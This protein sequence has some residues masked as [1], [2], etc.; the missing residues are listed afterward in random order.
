MKEVFIKYNPYKLETEIKIDGQAV[1]K[2]SALN[3]GEQRL[4]EWVEDLPDILVDEC[5]VKDFKLKFY[6]TVLDYED[7][8]SVASAAKKRGITIA[9]EHIPAKEVSDNVENILVAEA[10]SKELAIERFIPKM[11]KIK[12]NGDYAFLFDDK[13]DFENGIVVSIKPKLEIM[14]TDEYL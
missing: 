4:Q 10:G 8:M 13:S 5:N 6:G 14:S 2:N 12:R 11:I 9:V 7:I 3:I 1:K